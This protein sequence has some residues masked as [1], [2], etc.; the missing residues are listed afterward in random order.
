MER[1]ELESQFE[2]CI[3]EA[4]KYV[5]TI[6]D[7]DE[8]VD[9]WILPRHCLGPT[10]SHYV[11]HAIPREEKSES[12]QDETSPSS[13]LFIYLFIFFNFNFLLF[14]VEMTTKFNQELYARIMAKKNEPFFSIG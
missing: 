10:P 9:L 13:F 4:V 7:F 6:D 14:P 12:F 1:P 11:L 8:L 2:G 5:C 3:W